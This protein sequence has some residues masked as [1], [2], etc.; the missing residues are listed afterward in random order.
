MMSGE[1]VQVDADAADDTQVRW[2]G[3]Q[4]P[5]YGIRHENLAARLTRRNWTTKAVVRRDA[6]GIL[7]VWVGRYGSQEDPLKRTGDFYV[8]VHPFED[9]A[10]RDYGRRFPSLAAALAYANSEDGGLLAQETEPAAATECP[11]VGVGWT[12]VIGG[13]RLRRGS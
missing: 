2:A 11:E 8:A 12:V 4:D 5:V 1:F 3:P 6:G 10:L 13:F 7:Y 9:E